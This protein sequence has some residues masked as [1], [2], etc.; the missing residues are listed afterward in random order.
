MMIAL[1]G[2][3]EPE[4][5]SV[6]EKRAETCTKRIDEAL[7]D[8]D[9][10]Y[11]KSSPDR[12]TMFCAALAGDWVSRYSG[13]SPVIEPERAASHMEL[14]YKL[15]IDGA[16][17]LPRFKGRLPKPVAEMTLLGWEKL[18]PRGFFEGDIHQIY[19]WQV[20]SYQAC[21]HIYLG[22]VKEGL[23]TLNMIYSR[24]ERLG[25][26]FSADL[27]GETK[28]IYMTHPVA[29]AVLNAFTGAALDVP[30]G[31]LHLGPRMLPGEK[32]LRVPVFF[33]GFWAMLEYDPEKGFA[34]INVRKHFGKPAMIKSVIFNQANGG[35]KEILLEKPTLMEQGTIIN[36]RLEPLD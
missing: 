34:A 32:E 9:K 4:L 11:F 20:I 18:V 16:R 22:Q 19:I 2:H 13:L 3:V 29:W 23:D 17:N 10:G 14:A 5:A 26:A 36:I 1:A 30:K 7:W 15:L 31:V 6:F 24:L 25:Y 21:E 12:A 35:S 27:T 33:P 8:N 28:S